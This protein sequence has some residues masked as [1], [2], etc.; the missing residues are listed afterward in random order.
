M[1][2]YGEWAMT[3][4]GVDSISARMRGALLRADASIGPYNEQVVLR[5]GVGDAAPYKYALN[6]YKITC[7]CDFD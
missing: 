1:R 2:P 6:V 5:R 3:I 4:V 7:I